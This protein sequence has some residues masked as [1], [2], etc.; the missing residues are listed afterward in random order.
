MVNMLG[1]HRSQPCWTE[2]AA[3][4]AADRQAAPVRQ[5]T[6]QAQAKMGHINVLAP[7]VEEALAWIDD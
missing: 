2:A 7:S 1:E 4:A 5:S 6:K 3:K